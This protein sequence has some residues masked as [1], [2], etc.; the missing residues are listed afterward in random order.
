M[1]NAFNAKGKLDEAID[2]YKKAVSIKPDYFEAYNKA[3]LSFKMVGRLEEAVEAYKK[4]IS[5]RPDYCEAY[6]NMGV[7]LKTIGRLEEAI[8]AYKKAL[9]IRPDYC[10]AYNNMGN[11]LNEQGHIDDAIEAYNKALSI[12]PDNFE[13][14]FN[15]GNAFEYKGKINEAIKCYRQAISIK[16]DYAE[17]HRNLSS[18]TEY[19]HGDTHFMQVQELYDKKDVD[20]ESKCHLSFALAK[21]YEDIGAF[22]KAFEYFCEGNALRKKI[23]RYSISK[24]VDFVSKLKKGQPSIRSNSLI[25]N[26]LYLDIKPIFIVGM[27]RSGTTLVEQIISSHAEVTGAGE[28]PYIARYGTQLSLGLTTPNKKI[29]NTG[30]P[31]FQK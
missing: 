23:L 27:P 24:D 30:R 29:I 11:A 8:E 1:G 15:M 20:N 18:V 12:K 4:A 6:N 3:G 13:T 7:A 19:N 10:E 9:S 31:I 17:A 22:K 21:M 28:L 16:P 2:A 14:Y 25:T 5:I 26:D